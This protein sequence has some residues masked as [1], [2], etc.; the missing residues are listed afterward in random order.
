MQEDLGGQSSRWAARSS[1]VALLP[2][3]LLG[4]VAW[5]PVAEV[6]EDRGWDVVIASV[7]ARPSGPGDVLRCLL[8]A[9]PTERPLV[10][11]PHSNAGLYVPAIVAQREVA[12]VAFVDAALPG[13]GESTP[14]CPPH[15]RKILADIADSAGLLPPWTQWW[16]ETDLAPLFPSTQVR[17]RIEAGQPRLP[18]AYFDA[19]LPTAPGW[20]T[21]PIGY[22]AFGDTY[23]AERERAAE[24][25]WT[26]AT[27]SG[28]HLHM[29][30]DPAEVAASVLGLLSPQ[31]AGAP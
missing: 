12:A 10:L 19:A 3:P 2:S 14:M 18:L 28:A 27:L 17:D 1:L 21:R 13:D 15:L 11:V 20:E 26:V 6:L 9:L 24:A 4:P 8:D 16:G 25:G 30:V 7:P 29:L 22:L 31:D 5:E 23:A